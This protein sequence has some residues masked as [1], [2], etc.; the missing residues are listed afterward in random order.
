M[1]KWEKAK[2]LF[3]QSIFITEIRVELFVLIDKQQQIQP[4][5]VSNNIQIDSLHFIQRSTVWKG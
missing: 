1:Q 4:R 2:I 5:Q 3:T